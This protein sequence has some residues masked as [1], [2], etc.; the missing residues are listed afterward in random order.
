MNTAIEKT[1]DV[2]LS[3]TTYD[4]LMKLVGT[5]ALMRS[6]QKEY[7]ATK[8]TGQLILA[9]EYEKDVDH[10]LFDLKVRKPV[11][12]PVKAFDQDKIGRLIKAMVETQNRIDKYKERLQVT[13]VHDSDAARAI[14]DNLRDLEYDLAY[15]KNELIK[16]KEAF[17]LFLQN[18]LS[19]Y[20]N[21]L[22]AALLKPHEREEISHMINRTVKR[23]GELDVELKQLRA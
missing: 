9:K 12:E 6:A 10:Y 8:N 1:Q 2:T 15:A 13:D 18:R 14:H 21:E 7:F 11:P 19:A 22:E 23:I 5:V 20:N 16:E 4:T 3:A 17:K